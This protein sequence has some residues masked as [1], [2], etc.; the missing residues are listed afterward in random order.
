MPDIIQLLP[1]FVANQIAA[2]EVVQRP[3]SA[4]KEL[5]ENALDAE[6]STIQVIIK[7][8]G[9]TLIQVIDNGTGMSE[10][11]A[12]LCFMR[13]AT[14]KIKQ[15]TDLFQI[16]SMGFRGEALASIAAIAHVCLKTRRET[17]ELGTELTIEGGSI[18]N[19]QSITCPKGTSIEVKNLFF[20]IPARRNFLKST[21]VEFRHILEEFQRQALANSH[22]FFSLKQESNEVLHLPKSGLKQRIIHLFGNSYNE[23]LLPVDEDTGLMKVH[24]FIG[25]PEAA[26]KTRG[27]QYFFINGRFCRAPYFHHA[28]MNAYQELLPADSI[29]FYALFIDLDPA[30]IDINVHPSKT[31]I[32]FEDETVIYAILRAAVKRSLGQYILSPS[33]DFNGETGFAEFGLLKTEGVT[34]PHI[35]FNPEYNPFTNA[36]NNKGQ[37][38]PRNWQELYK[39]AES[40]PGESGLF[41]EAQT[42][43]MPLIPIGSSEKVP[44]QVHSRFIISSIKSG[45]LVIDQQAAHERILYEQFLQSFEGKA[46]PS[47]QTLFPQTI[48]LSASESSLMKELQPE[49]KQLGFEIREFGRHAF[50]IE[51]MPA[52]LGAGNET[53]LLE[54]L[55][56]SYKENL[57][58]LKLE[59]RDNLAR[60][61]ARKAAIKT[62]RKLEASEMALI[63]DQL[64]ACSNPALSP[65]GKQVFI[66]LGLEELV[67]KFEIQRF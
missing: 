22:L 19:V 47:Q 65:F 55:L 48:Q 59:K 44:F 31:E 6:A 16:R 11:D 58:S 5:I 39:I 56:E 25:I 40:E 36:G 50:I 53:Q 45:L 54:S 35:P 41:E 10:A 15:A 7:D 4:V 33:I 12:R 13:H 17:D 9:K 34:V 57:S 63:I 32:K 26:K 27:E 20:N 60:S 61:L 64:F 38:I 2:G 62:G 51:G 67:K 28:L 24:G 52:D 14:S 37:I 3:S 42:E 66:T 18:K 8:G 43:Q 49:L 46:N 23:K 29:P 21:Q 30:K 1:E